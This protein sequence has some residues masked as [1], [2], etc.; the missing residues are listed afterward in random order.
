MN[1]LRNLAGFYKLQGEILWKWRPGRRALI[2]RLI[3]S[4]IGSR[5]SVPSGTKSSY[6]TPFT[7]STA[8]P[9]LPRSTICPVS[10]PIT[11]GRIAGGIGAA[12]TQSSTLRFR[13]QCA[14][15]P[16]TESLYAGPP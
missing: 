15:R 6:P 2:R 14:R 1:A 8:A 12:Y 10:L 11:G 7:S 13:G 4:F 5:P 9:S 3:V 16:G